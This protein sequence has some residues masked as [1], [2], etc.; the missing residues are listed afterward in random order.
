MRWLIFF[1]IFIGLFCKNTFASE[2][3][4]LDKFN[5]IYESSLGPMTVCPTDENWVYAL[6]SDKLRNSGNAPFILHHQKP[7]NKVMVLFHGLSDSP[8]YLKSIAPFAHSRG[9]TVITALSPGHGLQSAD[10]AIKASKLKEQ[11][12][13]HAADIIEFA[14]AIGSE[15]WVGGFSTGGAIATF[16]ALS[17]P[18]EVDGLVLFSGALQLSPSIE[19]L[20][21]I[22]GMHWILNLLAD[23]NY[24]DSPNPYKYK[25]IPK[26]AAFEL[27][28]LIK[29]IRNL[30]NNDKPLSLPLFAAHSL[31]DKATLWP[32]VEKLL[33]YNQG[34]SESFLI[35]ESLDVCH[36]DVVINAPQLSLMD[37]DSE[38][39][40]SIDKCDKPHANPKH[41][42][43]MN[44]FTDFLDTHATN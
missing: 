4:W 3:A 33:G 28:R 43:M 24:A 32:G 41:A 21:S 19:R 7:T 8:F 9:F 44:A 14:N 22:W 37:Y 25:Q 18:D 16:H 38:K 36:A 5:E 1:I 31:A 10:D 23:D 2:R 39:I 30:I 15:V 35:E 20:G 29:D 12:V 40:I 42:M 34:V 6:C 17:H 13:A 26:P 27:V 11:W